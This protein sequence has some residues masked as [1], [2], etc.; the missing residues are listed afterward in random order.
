MFDGVAAVNSHGLAPAGLPILFWGAFGTDVLA[1][2]FA[3][4]AAI[5][6]SKSR[7]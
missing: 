7:T 2:G 5:H 4:G 6:M 3:A 1:A